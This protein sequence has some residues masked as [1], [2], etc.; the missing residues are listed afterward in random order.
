[1]R[2]HIRDHAPVLFLLLLLVLP[3]CAGGEAADS[4]DATDGQMTG[5][6]LTLFDGT[7]LD[8]WK[9]FQRDDVPGGWG[10]E[11]GLLKFTPGVE[12][13]D[14]VTRDQFGDFELA[15]E[16]RVSPGGNS[17]IL[18]RVSE[19][20][21]RIWEEAPEMQILDNEGHPNGDDPL[22]SAGS[23]YALDAPTADV[24]KPAGEWNSTRIVA[25][26]NHIEHWLNGTKI[27]EYEI[28][29]P[30]WTEKVAASKFS[31]WPDY[32]LHPRGHI[33]LQDH[34]DPVWFR[35]IRIRPLDGDA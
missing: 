14:I 20:A 11:D 25:R 23:N 5:E 10:I 21:G 6:W 1:M 18:Y 9:G 16:W 24:A 34:G 26:G 27:V 28:G 29:S 4:A 33:G 30:E 8:A 31:E 35:D 19:D 32:G 13:G 7:S 12:G 15:L 2:I 22:T 17:G 3:A